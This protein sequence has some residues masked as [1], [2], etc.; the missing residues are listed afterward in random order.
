M[1]QSSGNGNGE[2]VDGSFTVE[3]KPV[4]NMLVVIL[5]L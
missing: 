5:A 3:E 4:P 2:E 1:K